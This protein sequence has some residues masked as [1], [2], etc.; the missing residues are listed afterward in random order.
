MQTK[1]RICFGLGFS[2]ANIRTFAGDSV[3]L[4]PCVYAIVDEM[5]E[6]FPG[7]VLKTGKSGI[8]LELK[9]LGV[10]RHIAR[11]TTSD[12]V[13]ESA[14]YSEETHRS[15]MRDFVR[16]FVKKY[17]GRFLTPPTLAETEHQTGISQFYNT[18]LQEELYAEHGFPGCVA[19]GDCVHIPW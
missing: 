18:Q 12:C 7:T 11:D 8:P 9:I 16:A 10:L 4:Q 1:G 2:H 3:S 15:F 13:A 19:S 6:D 5:Y 14:G 17:H